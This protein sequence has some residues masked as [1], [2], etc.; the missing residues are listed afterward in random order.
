MAGICAR[1]FGA[2]V[3]V[4]LT[5]VEGV[6]DKPP[7]IPGA[8]KL[9]IYRTLTSEVAIGEKSAQ[10]ELTRQIAIHNSVTMEI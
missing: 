3:L 4:L 8:K 1:S 5:D 9:E 6:Y 10:G 7:T 2:E